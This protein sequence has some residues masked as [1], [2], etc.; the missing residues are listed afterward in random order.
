VSAEARFRLY[1]RTRTSD[2]LLV[3]WDSL[4]YLGERIAQR[5]ARKVAKD[6]H[7]LEVQVMPA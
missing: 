5:E 4:T 3:R 2:G 6:P 7:V 1:C